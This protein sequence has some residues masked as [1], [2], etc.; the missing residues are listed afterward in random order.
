MCP[1]DQGN[2]SAVGKAGIAIA[3]GLVGALVVAGTAY[4]LAASPQP[5]SGKL[6]VVA[7]F[8]PY[9]YFATRIGGGT[10]EVT[11]LLPPGVEPHDWEPSPS[12]ILSIHDADAFI[13][14]GYV[15][16]FLN[17]LFA[18]LPQDRPARVNTS[19][20]IAIRTTANGEVDP[21]VWLDPVLAKQVA[22]TIA[23]AFSALRPSSASLFQ[24]NLDA[25]NADLDNLNWSYSPGLSTCN[26]HIMVTQH[27]AFGYLASRYNLT[28]VAIQGLSP[29]QQPTPQKLKEIVDIVSRTHVKYIFYEELVNP[30]VAETIAEAAGVR[31][32]VLDPIEGLT[33]QGETQGKDY[34]NIMAPQNLDALRLA[35]QCS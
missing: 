30:A 17:S 33:Q 31:T 19:Q 35:L 3:I 5:A 2:M 9:Y 8:Y 4:Y 18:E 34:M 26:I 16:V 29:D 25:L 21:H 22:G 6:K 24:A 10:A 15:E 12:A 32:M 20:G 11:N 27:E 23:H 13:Y 7:S 1:V 28:Q 14:N